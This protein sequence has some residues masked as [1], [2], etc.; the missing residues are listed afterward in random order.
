[1][2]NFFLLILGNVM[3]LLLVVFFL[4]VS[5]SSNKSTTSE[6]PSSS[7]DYS[8]FFIPS[9]NFYYDDQVINDE[10][11]Q[12]VDEGTEIEINNNLVTVHGDLTVP[13]DDSINLSGDIALVVEGSVY[14]CRCHI[15]ENIYDI[16]INN[17]TTLNPVYPEWW[18]AEA[19]DANPALNKWAIRQ[20]IDSL[21]INGGTIELDSGEYVISG[22]LRISDDN[23]TIVGVEDQTML[24]ATSGNSS[25]L[26]R[27]AILGDGSISVENG[28][29]FQAGGNFFLR[30][31][32]STEGYKNFLGKI[33][34]VVGNEIFLVRN[35][36]DSFF[37]SQNSVISSTFPVMTIDSSNN[38]AI[39]DLM[40]DGN[41][42]DA[43]IQSWYLAG[44][45]VS[46]STD[47]TIDN[48]EIS[49]AGYE[50]ITLIANEDV[51]V[52][53]S[54][55]IGSKND[56]IHLGSARNNIIDN[57]T[58]IFSG[59]D[60]VYFCDDN[61]N[62]EVSNNTIANSSAYG[63]GGIGSWGRGSDISPI[64]RLVTLDNNIIFNSG[65]SGIGVLEADSISITSNIIYSSSQSQPH[66]C[67]IY[68]SRS[69][70]ITI[71][72]NSVYDHQEGA[73]CY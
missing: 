43:G 68:V 30:D 69:Q 41:K 31:D 13:E 38:I 24:K 9:D 11:S 42:N 66:N 29:L 28:T 27:D 72:S 55:I 46:H 71:S 17:E 40:I 25:F 62:V 10:L 2:K 54:K 14:A 16:K 47:V 35:I 19:S 36:N 49:D 34:H 18:G 8:S 32:T 63:I 61:L 3:R 7:E 51:T 65:Y 60:G 59:A 70:N 67:G 20:A 73:E 37:V 4:N 44:I 57:N 21:S 15:F 58:I 50:G 64:D 39:R 45:V 6:S 48:V 5:C 23:I 53:N 12:F 56:G 22:Q 1:M 26:T 33:D 52:T